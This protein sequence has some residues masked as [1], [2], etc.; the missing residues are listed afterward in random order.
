MVRAY[1]VSKEFER[2]LEWK[3]NLLDS[4][5]VGDLLYVLREYEENPRG[6]DKEVVEKVKDSLFDEGIMCI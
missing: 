2:P 5:S 4:Y 6:Y 1:Q 3:L